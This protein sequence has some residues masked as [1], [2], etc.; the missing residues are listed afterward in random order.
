MPEINE[1]TFRENISY[2]S[3][4]YKGLTNPIG[5]IEYC[6]VTWEA[7][8]RQEWVHKFV[9]TFDMIPRNW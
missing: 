9:H 6:H 1:D 3:K 4:K 8:L 2:T 7:F 5:H